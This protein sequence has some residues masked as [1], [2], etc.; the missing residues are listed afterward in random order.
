[1]RYHMPRSS[2][3]QLLEEATSVDLEIPSGE[4]KLNREF[5]L[6]NGNVTNMVLDFDGEKSIKETEDG[7]YIMTPVIGILSVN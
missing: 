1:M 5:D 2:D 7:R 4:V 6:T 3:W